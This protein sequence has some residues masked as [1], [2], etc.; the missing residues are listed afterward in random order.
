MTRVIA[1]AAFFALAAILAP[2]AA[3]GARVEIPFYPMHSPTCAA[4]SL[5]MV[6]SFYGYN[7]SV[8]LLLQ[9]MGWDYGAFYMPQYHFGYGI[10]VYPVNAVITACRYLGFNVTVLR[11]SSFSKAIEELRSYL[12]SGVPV[13]LQLR[14]HTI[15]ATGINGSYI[16]V[17]DPS[18]GIYSCK[19]VELASYLGLGKELGDHLE[20]LKRECRAGGKDLAIPLERLRDLWES[21][22]GY[23]TAIVVKPS[24]PVTSLSSIDWGSVLE[25]AAELERGSSYPYASGVYAWMEFARDLETYFT[26]VSSHSLELFW[27]AETML[28]IASARRLDAASFLE[29]LAASSGCRVLANASWAL[30]RASDYFARARQL[31]LWAIAHRNHV[32]ESR[33]AVL[34]AAKYVKLGAEM[35]AKAARLLDEASTCFRNRAGGSSLGLLGYELIATCLAIAAA[36][37]ALALLA[38]RLRI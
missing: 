18:G 13:I 22:Y 37:I 23:F 12:A 8:S 9:L 2:V 1:L 24:K 38:K 3:S 35:D 27:D 32:D 25:R 4:R 11:F 20:V 19:V 33:K 15:V 7:Y 5:Q 21:W 34:E 31:V 10:G 29:G 6:L 17:N 14:E 26:N 30:E 16:L 36:A 28:E